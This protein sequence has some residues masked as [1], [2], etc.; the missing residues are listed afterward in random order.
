MSG[1]FSLLHGPTHTCQ[2]RKDSRSQSSPPDPI[3][4]VP[5]PTSGRLQPDL[6]L[7]G[8]KALVYV[9]F[10]A[11]LRHSLGM[12]SKNKFKTTCM[13]GVWANGK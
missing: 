11:V 10:T 5:L 7:P 4:S 12:E 2:V 3:I 1:V 8:V 6:Q 9:C 13:S